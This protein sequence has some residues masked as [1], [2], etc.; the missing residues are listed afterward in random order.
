MEVTLQKFKS[1][2]DHYLNEVQKG[3]E[4]IIRHRKKAVARLAPPEIIQPEE[5][6]GESE[7]EL[8]E[9][10]A[11]GLIRLPE[12]EMDEKFWDDFFALPAPNISLERAITAVVA[13]RQ[14][15]RY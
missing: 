12:R 10:E 11:G 4:V 9:L 8:R 6:G 15:N 5:M 2:I 13:D 14:E 1:N 7:A 3:K